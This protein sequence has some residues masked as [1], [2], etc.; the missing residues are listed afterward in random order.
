MKVAI[1][2]QPLGYNYGG[3]LQ[4]YA[5]QRY[6][7]KIGCDVETINRLHNKNK[8]KNFFKKHVK[9]SIG[10]SPFKLKLEKNR[11]NAVHKELYKFLYEYINISEEIFTDSDLIKYFKRNSFDAVIVGSDQVWR[12]KYSPNIFNYS[13]SF[14]DK[15]SSQKIKRISYAASFGVGYS[16]FNDKQIQNF[17]C[18]LQKFDAISVR[19][20]DA[21]TLC[22]DLFNA[23]A[24]WVVDPTLLLERN[25]YIKI[26]ANVKH[27]NYKNKILNYVLDSEASK[28]NAVIMVSEALNMPYFSLT[29]ETNVNDVRSGKNEQIKAHLA[30]GEWLRAFM[31][32]EYVITDSFHGTV[33]SILFNKPFIVIGNKDRGLSRFETLLSKFGLEERFVLSAE[34]LDV[35]QLQR[36]IDW[37][38]IND[39]IEFYRKDGQSFLKEVVNPNHSM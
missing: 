28:Q 14:L 29:T 7:I 10:S 33:F 8:V 24:T 20:L 9:K 5:L 4:A 15:V 30:V 26:A 27:T 36:D 1:L 12:P 35:T 3:L 39:K 25:D 16:E 18:S 21:V 38:H 23:D 32:A 2:T 17:T 31:D 11:K 19:E 6:L 22:K 34:D 37:G 13:L